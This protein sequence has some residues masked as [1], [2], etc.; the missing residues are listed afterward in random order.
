[1]PLARFALYEA[2]VEIYIASTADD[3]DAWQSTLVHI[4]RESRAYVV[5]PSAFQRASSYPDDFGL[6]SEIE[7]AGVLGRG[8]SAILAP[9][10]SY[11]AG[12]LY[13]EEGILYAG[14]DPYA[15]L[16][17]GSGSTQSAS[18]HRRRRAAARRQPFGSRGRCDAEYTS[19][20]LINPFSIGN[21]STPSHSTPRALAVHSQT[22]EDS[23]ARR[24]TVEN[25]RS[26]LLRKIA[27][28]CSRTASAPSARSSAVWLWNTTSGWCI[29]WIASTSCAFHA[30]L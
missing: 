10:G 3:G 8:G 30:P 29:E 15:Y 1:M 21:T 6:A 27:A 5:S 22:A 23:P 26:G 13:D 24:L 4:A 18:Y 2:G 14:F 20:R 28:M 11:L 19:F 7:G 12:P 17:S 16:R 25:R 9:D